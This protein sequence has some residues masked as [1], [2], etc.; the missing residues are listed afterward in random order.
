MFSSVFHWHQSVFVLH[1]AAERARTPPTQALIAKIHHGEM[2]IVIAI[3]KG[4][5]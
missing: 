3:E 1:G 5:G 2:F 4:S